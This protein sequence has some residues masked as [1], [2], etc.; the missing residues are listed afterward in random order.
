M[1]EMAVEP[2]EIAIDAKVLHIDFDAVDARGLALIPEL[3]R[4]LAP[5]ADQLV[6]A[7]VALGGQMRGGARGHA[8]ADRSAI[9]DHHVL[10]GLGELV[11]H[12]HAGDA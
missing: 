5:A 1:K 3:G 11:S 12:R 2:P 8:L 7:V 6:E 9:N 4:L 10:A